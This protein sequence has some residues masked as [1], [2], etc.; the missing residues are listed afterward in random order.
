MINFT[1][2]STMYQIELIAQKD[3]FTDK[4]FSELFELSTRISNL[5]EAKSPKKAMNTIKMYKCLESELLEKFD[6]YGGDGGRMSER[7]RTF[8]VAAIPYVNDA[9]KVI[10]DM[11]KKLGV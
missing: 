6:E 7:V 1:N 8:E 11:K 10:K 4:Q 9:L 3:K 2:I 5:K